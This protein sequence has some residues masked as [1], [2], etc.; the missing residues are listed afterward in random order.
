MA[1]PVIQSSF[2]SGEW[3]PN[4]WA[5]TDLDKYQSGAALLRNF[6]VDYRGGAS[7]RS[8]TRYIL[9]GYKD[10]TAIRL[11]PFQA[12]IEVGYMLEFGEDYIRFYRD[13]APILETGLTITGATKASTCQLTVANTYTTGDVDWIYVSGVGGMTQLNGKFFIVHARTATTVDL[14]DLF[15]NPVDSTSYTTYTSG[16]TTQRIYTISSPYAAADLA[17][18]KFVQNVNTLILT[19]PSYVPYSLTYASATSWALTAITFGSTATA[20]S[21]VTAATTLAAGSVYYNYAVT[22]VD[23]DGQESALSTRAVLNAK[24]DLRTVAGTNTVSWDP[25]SGAA[26]YNV[27]KTDVSYAGAIPIGAPFGFIGNTTAVS[28]P[29]S[30]IVADFSQPPPTTNNPFA[31]GSIVTAVTIDTAGSY[32]TAPTATF[33]A[34]TAPL[35]GTTATGTPVLQA[36]T[37]TVSAGG[38]GYEVGDTITLSNNV[39]LTVATVA[40]GPP[41]PAATATITFAGS[42]ST[43][44]SN[45]VAQISSSGAG[46]SS[47]WT[48]TWGVYAMTITNHGGGY[49]DPTDI[50]TITF[51]AGAATAT[52]TLGPASVGNPAV[53]TFFQQRLV[54][55]A[56]TSHPQTLYL[57]QPG[58]YY[59]YDVST[60]SQDDDAITA[61]LVS[62]QLVNIQSMVP[63]P[64]GLIVFTDGVSFLINGGTLGSSITPASITANAQSYLGANDMPPIV[65]NFDILTVSSK[66]SSVRDS[67]YN[68]YANVFTGSDISIISSHLFFGYELTQWAWAEEPYKIVWATRNDGT[69][70]SLTFIKEQ[71]F[72]AWSHH[73]TEDGDAT[74]DSV[75][76]IVEAASVG[77]QNFV[78]TV[79]SRTINS[80]DVK[81]IEYF[82]ERG[83]TND[84]EDYWTVDCGIQ[85]NGSPATDFTG[86][87]FLVGKT[88][89]GLADGVEITPFVMPADGNFTLPTAASVVTVGLAFTCDLQTLYIDTGS[90]TIQSHQKS[91]PAVTVRVTQTLGLSIGTD[92]D[93][94]VT[95]KDL[96]VGNVGSMTNEVVAGLVTGDARTYLNPK[97]QATGQ[98][99]IRQSKPYPATILGVMPQLTVGDTPKK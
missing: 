44:P 33:S 59:N 65:V 63:Q 56:P 90:P 98:F 81:Y 13:G 41:G 30:N 2:N 27:Y 77:Y 11:I 47:T 96:V 58:N 43:L 6:F 61:S 50:P 76:T 93:N 49:V 17:L 3:A 10:S 26:S 12:S 4:L 45:P 73:D 53:P 87:E 24:T 54:L 88:C 74:F 18:L 95:M 16:G 97:W 80:V 71:D 21:N 22:S 28:F 60:P 9:R 64:G 8:G 29:D 66:G 36:I 23:G 82:P 69:L 48:L 83:L 67:T 99:Y 40:S 57:S 39:V 19:H 5:R 38:T 55:A 34:P 25:V 62:G 7:T 72:I 85:Y 94:L 70:L 79:V 51:S 78:Y 86:G 46:V 35:G 37:A 91:L 32:T 15:G 20:P 1:Q 14:Y 31:T 92:T 75:A 68:F 52:A 42:T 89:V 84:A